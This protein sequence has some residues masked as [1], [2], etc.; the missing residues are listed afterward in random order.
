MYAL[1]IGVKSNEASRRNYRLQER[2]KREMCAITEFA[3]TS[4]LLN[5]NHNKLS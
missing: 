4:S 3:F 5:F 2:R 1:L